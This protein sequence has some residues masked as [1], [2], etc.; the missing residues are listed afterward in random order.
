MTANLRTLTQEKRELPMKKLLMPATALAAMK[1]LAFAIF[2]ATLLMLMAAPVWAQ[3]P[4]FEFATGCGVTITI[5]G[6]SGH[7]T[8]Q[9]S[10]DGTANGNPYDHSEDIL[11]G[12]VNNSTAT[13]GAIVLNGSGAF[14]FDGDG[15]SGGPD[16]GDYQGPTNTFVGISSDQSTGKVLFT[17]PLAAGSSTWFAL[18]NTPITVV[19]IGENKPLTAGQTT[20]FSFGTG[21]VDDYRITPVNSAPGDTMTITPIPVAS[22]DFHPTNFSTL[23]CVPYK[24]FSVEN[25]VCVEI[26]RDCLG[27]DCGTF[28]YSATLDFNIDPNSHPDGIG[29]AAFLGQAD[30]ACPTS[31]FNLN[32]T[33]SYTGSPV[34]P[35]TGSGKGGHSCFVAAFDPTVPNV[36]TGA[37]VSTF[38]GF[39]FPVV[40]NPKVNT[41]FPPLPVP[42]SWDTHDSSNNGV[43]NLKL[44]KVVNPTGDCAGLG[45]PW[46]HL[47]STAISGCAAFTGEDPLPGVFLNLSKIIGAGEYTFVWDTS[48]KKGPSGCK[49]SVVLQFDTGAFDAPATFKYH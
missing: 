36:A 12:V 18:E 8:A 7:L 2:C 39:E 38:F 4:S 27:A 5:G 1:K 19:A 24:D 31:G 43:P 30:V 21:N 29:G 45:K 25:P 32:I 41:I 42:L 9:L 46:V 26:E 48:K 20:I 13:V 44:C 16:P 49:V 22:N 34:D 14:A 17:T 11:V 37:T 35:I 33:T 40:N 3:C 23:S 10:G 47:S 6:S 28:L 15:P